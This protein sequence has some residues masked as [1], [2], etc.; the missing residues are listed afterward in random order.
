MKPPFRLPPSAFCVALAAFI[1][2]HSSFSIAAA[3]P[4]AAAAQEGVQ[5]WE[6]GPRWADRNVGAEEPWEAGLYA[7]AAIF[8]PAAGHGIGIV[9]RGHGS[10][11]CLWASE[12]YADGR[13][14]DCTWRLRFGSREIGTNFCWD[15]YLATPV[16][17][18]RDE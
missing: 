4:P 10:S 9:R 14:S 13:P 2:Q 11:G 8:L 12:P 7:S 15:R 5:L 17:P 18:V 3:E 1:I 16:R 6:D